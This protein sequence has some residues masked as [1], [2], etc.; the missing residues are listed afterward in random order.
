MLVYFDTLDKERNIKIKSKPEDI[1]GAV[2]EDDDL[3]LL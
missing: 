1:F 3:I 2:D